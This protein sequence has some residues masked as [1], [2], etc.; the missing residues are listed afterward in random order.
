MTISGSRNNPSP[1][2]L[3]EKRKTRIFRI[4]K[5]TT[6][7]STRKIQTMKRT[8]YNPAQA[9]IISTATSTSPSLIQAKEGGKK[10]VKPE[11]KAGAEEDPESMPSK[12]RK[13]KPTSLQAEKEA[14]LAKIGLKMNQKPP[15]PKLKRL[16]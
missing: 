11:R 5:T 16:T 14:D 8:T 15:K 1:K 10:A 7:T 13:P 9:R 6:T 3:S 4:L 12:T 2:V